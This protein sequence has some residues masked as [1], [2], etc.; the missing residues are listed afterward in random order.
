MCVCVCVCERERESLLKAY[1]QLGFTDSAD[2]QCQIQ[3]NDETGWF[4]YSNDGD[5]QPYG[6][7]DCWWRI[8]VFTDKVISMEF[9]KIKVDDPSSECGN[10]EVR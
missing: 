1:L 9:Y 5:V 3:L 2:S 7:L 8:E 4:G 10:L 6:T